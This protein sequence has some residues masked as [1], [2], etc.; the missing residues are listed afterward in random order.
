VRSACDGRSPSPAP[1]LSPPHAPSASPASTALLDPHARRALACTT[2]RARSTCSS[3]SP[4]PAPRF[5]SPCPPLP[6][7]APPL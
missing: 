3:R 1:L 4:S 7:P 5:S 2:P 6:C